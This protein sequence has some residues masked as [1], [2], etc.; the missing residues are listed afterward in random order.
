MR[1]EEITPA[2]LG[3]ALGLPVLGTTCERVGTGLMA[4]NFRYR[5]ELDGDAPEGAPTSVVAKLPADDDTSRA[6]G[7]NLGSYE[8]EVRFYDELAPSLAIRTPT[9]HLA[10]YDAEAPDFTLLLEDLAPARQGDQIAGSTLEQ[11]GVAMDEVAALHGP[12]WNDRSLETVPWLAR[13][14]ERGL[15]LQGLYQAFWPPF[16][17]T[18]AKYLTPEQLELGER[19]G[20]VVGAFIEGLPDPIT[21]VHGDFRL[22]NMMFATPE[23]GYP[24][25]V[26]DWQTLALAFPGIDIAYFL[27]AGLLPEARREHERALLDRYRAGLARFGVSEWSA[28]DVWEAYRLG[29][30]HGVFMSV[31]SPNLVAVTDRSEAMFAAMVTRHFTHVQDVDAAGVLPS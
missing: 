28:D 10:S 5:L 13:P 19:Y 4:M 14:P 27:G 20:A 17:A 22:E 9:C 11:A 8:R 2:W 24:L 26:V 25:A 30:W 6:T 16:C 12:R 18:F 7:F 21:V 1:P 15:L 31:I 3:E 23:G 29:A